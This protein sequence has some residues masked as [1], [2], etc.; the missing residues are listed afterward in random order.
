MN[1]PLRRGENENKLQWLVSG[2][3]ALTKESCHFPLYAQSQGLGLKSCIPDDHVQERK[4]KEL[5]ITHSQYR[6]HCNGYSTQRLCEPSAKPIHTS[7][8]PFHNWSSES[9]CFWLN[10]TWG[11]HQIRWESWWDGTSPISDPQPEKHRAKP[12]L[13]STSPGRQRQS[14]QAYDKTHLGWKMERVQQEGAAK[15]R[16]LSQSNVK[17]KRKVEIKHCCDLLVSL[18]MKKGYKEIQH[19]CPASSY[20]DLPLLRLPASDGINSPKEICHQGVEIICHLETL[21]LNWLCN[22]TASTEGR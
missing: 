18:W 17:I 6:S 2:P 22:S 3:S 12:L 14:H 5:T 15:E 8:N 21:E 1:C 10:K 7:F 20:A 9:G 16:R 4:K 19:Q 13:R 11:H